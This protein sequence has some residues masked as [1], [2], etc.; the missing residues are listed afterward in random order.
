MT[1]V[2]K[3]LKIVDR[4]D[5]DTLAAALNVPLC[6]NRLDLEYAI[7]NTQKRVELRELLILLIDK[8]LRLEEETAP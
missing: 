8:E 2:A 6:R 1:M 5:L 7:A 4:R 3:A